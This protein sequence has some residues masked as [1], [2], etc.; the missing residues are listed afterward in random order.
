ML[1]TIDVASAIERSVV[2]LP[3]DVLN[4]LPQL[5]NKLPDDHYRL[6]YAEQGT[7]RLI[8]DVMVRRGKPID[9]TDDSEGTQDRP[10]T[11]TRSQPTVGHR[12]RRSRGAAGTRTV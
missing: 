2:V 6:Y 12:P 11:R 7:E 9:P 8:M 1:R 5:F 4:N 3:V 10:P